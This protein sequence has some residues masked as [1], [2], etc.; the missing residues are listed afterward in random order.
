MKLS[1]AQGEAAEG[2]DGAPKGGRLSE[3]G[4]EAKDAPAGSGEGV[5]AIGALFRGFLQGFQ[6]KGL[7]LTPGAEAGRQK[8]ETQINQQADQAAASHPIATGAGRIGGNI[9]AT[10]PLMGGGAG[11]TLP[12]RMGLGALR[13][14]AAAAMTPGTGA[15]GTAVGAGIG[16]AIPAAGAALAPAMPNVAEFAQNIASKFP[17]LMNFIRGTEERT[18]DGFDRSVARQVL[19]PIGGAVPR[20]MKAGDGLIDHV[21]TQFDRAFEEVKPSLQLNLNIGQGAWRTYEPQLQEIQ[22]GLPEAGWVN[23]FGHFLADKIA[24]RFD[25]KTGIMDGETFKTVESELSQKVSRAFKANNDELAAAYEDV[26]ELFRDSLLKQNPAQAPQLQKINQGYTMYYRMSRAASG[27][28]ADGKFTPMDLAGTIKR[29]AG[30]TDAFARGKAPTG[31]PTT[32]E[33]KDVLQLYAR[34][35]DKVLKGAKVGPMD[36]LHAIHPSASMIPAAGRAMM[37]GG[38]GIGRGIK[39]TAPLTSPAA[40]RPAGS[41]GQKVADR[42]NASRKVG[43]IQT[44]LYSAKRK[45]DLD[46]VQKLTRDLSGAQADYKALQPR[47]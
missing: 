35:G 26:R 44:K 12:A 11:A 21:R 16:A 5:S 13:G 10:A 39:Q 23:S 34:L 22:R 42:M 20:N 27:K 32:P 36:L 31:G 38:A 37:R 8:V 14:G 1:E 40:G 9:A 15:P 28:G 6:V 43:E 47:Q 2:P 29:Q 24:G 33:G 3:V 17:H 30:D 45:G 4:G 19:E 25:P 46:E 41:E 7:P 18:V